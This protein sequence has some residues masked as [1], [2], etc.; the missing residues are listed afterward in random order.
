MPTEISKNTRVVIGAGSIAGAIILILS[1]G[2][3][4]GS[5][6]TQR[7]N[8]TQTI[9]RH[10]EEISGLQK[11]YEELKLSMSE[12]KNE[13]TNARETLNKIDRMT[14]AT[15]GELG[16]IKVALAETGLRVPKD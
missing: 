1:V 8:N 16:N 10:E 5:L 6:D 12:V 4:W 2:H 9:S 3:W 14:I 11:S 7:E 13:Q 15:Y